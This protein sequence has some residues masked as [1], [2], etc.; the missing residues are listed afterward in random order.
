M[1][2]L[3]NPTTGFIYLGIFTIVMIAVT[4]FFGKKFGGKDV[5]GFLVA[6]R[7]V[8]WWIGGSSIAASWTWS[9]ALM[10]SVQ[11]AYEKGL[12]GLFWFIVPN[13]IAVIIF[14]WLAPKIRK[15]FPEGYSLPEWMHHKYSN[16]S[17]TSL[18]I[19]V[20]F[21][22]QIMAAAM[23]IYAGANLLY[24]ATGIPAL[25]LM[26]I[27]FLIVLSYTII[28]GLR[29]SMVTD[30]IQLALMLI[31]G[32]FTSYLVVKSIDG[33]LI[34]SGTIDGGSANPFTSDFLLSGGVIMT[35]S[36]ISASIGD[37]Q[38]WQ[39][40]FAIKEKDL[41]KSFIFGA[42]LFA[43]IPISLGLI[44]F[45]GASIY[46]NLTIPE[47]MDMSL[48]GFVIV[49]DLLPAGMATVFLFVLMAGLASTLD[50]AFSASSSLFRL[51]KQNPWSSNNNTVN[52]SLKDGRI[53]MV[54][55][56]LA[57]LLIGYLVE[58]VPGFDLKYFWWSL[59]TLT[60]AIVIPTLLSLFWSKLKPKGIIWG[61][62]L[63]LLTGLPIFV[64]GSIIK[65]DYFLA[66][67]YVVIV[68]ISALG[69]II[70]SKNRIS[71][72]IK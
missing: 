3:V 40:S 68:L 22:Y 51:V 71:K 27:L 48:I 69:C 42:I 43:A 41:R 17:I 10:I 14:I 60:S 21:Y 34:F 18:Y 35:I 62:S 50:S 36:L 61:S 53:A 15:S 39:R 59:N 24:V 70:G 45:S 56:G 64:Y 72:T 26:P 30:F 16:K 4:L 7:K 19:G 37:Q 2:N 32:I 1:E 55:I 49:K 47:N 57:G 46:E 23:Q 9:I 54:L 8:P 11:L 44:G 20:Y 52:F 67:A 12:A 65:N 28:S 5:D 58:L 29:A 13:F 38:F 31:L 6:G 66:L 33:N 25:T 63:A